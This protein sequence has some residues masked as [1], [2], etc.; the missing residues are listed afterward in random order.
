MGEPEETIKRASFPRDH[1]G[2]RTGASCDDKARS[3]PVPSKPDA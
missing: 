3:N 2:T 1:P